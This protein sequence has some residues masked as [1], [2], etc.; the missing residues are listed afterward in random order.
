MLLKLRQ[1]NNSSSF[2]DFEVSDDVYGIKDINKI[3]IAQVIRWQLHKSSGNK[4]YTKT[5]SEVAGSGKKIYRQ[6]G[7]GNARHSDKYAPQFRKGGTAHGP[8]ALQWTMTV[9][10]KVRKL[11]LR[12]AL[13]SKVQNGGIIIVDDM[14]M[15]LPKTSVVLSY[16]R[17]YIGKKV[18]F[19]D[20]QDYNSNFAKSVKNVV[21]FNYLSVNGLNVYDIIRS[22]IIFLTKDAVV[23]IDKR[24]L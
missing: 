4:S 5:R 18:L 17:D 24:L 16:F 6:K 11:A 10:K 1:L 21:D 19:I 13:S 7:T 23:A 20:G 14:S 2:T 22:D 12:N 15:S 8:K 3:V 9:P